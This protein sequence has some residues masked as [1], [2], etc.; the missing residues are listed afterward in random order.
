[1]DLDAPIV[2]RAVRVLELAQDGAPVH[3]GLLSIEV[4]TRLVW[5]VRPNSKI[6]FVS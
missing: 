3:T 2:P 5:S 6:D 4:G 1:M